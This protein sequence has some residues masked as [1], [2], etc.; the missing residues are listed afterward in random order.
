MSLAGSGVVA[1]WH[2]LLPEAKADFY[3]WHDRE[4]MPERV[5]RGR[6]QHC[7]SMMPPGPGPSE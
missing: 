4:H 7:V 2:D 6:S 3:E 1:I 5:A